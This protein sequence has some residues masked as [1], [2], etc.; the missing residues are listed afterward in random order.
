M[1]RTT[2]PPELLVALDRDSVV[3]LRVQLEGELRR[4]IRSDRLTAETPLPSTRALAADLG[5]SR[6]VVVEAYDQLLA[7]GYLKAARGSATRVATRCSDCGDE[8]PEDATAL[9][10]RYDF[11]PGLPDLALFPRAEWLCA[12]RY[13]VMNTAESTFDYPDP[14]GAHSARV[15]LAAYL[16]RVRGTSARADRLLFCTGSSQG[17]ALIAQVLRE[18]GL[19]RIAVEDPGL[20]DQYEVLVALGLE[21]SRVPVDDD[22]LRVDRLARTR[23]HAVLVTPAHQYPTGAVLSP[24]RRAALLAWAEKRGGIVI[25]DDYDAEYRYD[26]QPV[27][28]LQGLAPDRVVY[29]G[30]ASKTLSP[31]LRLAWLISPAALAPDLARAKKFADFGSPVPEQLALEEFLER[32]DYDRHIRRTRNIYRRRRD[33]LVAA[34]GRHVPGLRIRG[35]A[36]GLHLMVELEEGADEP[37]IAASAAQR[38]IRVFG[39]RKYRGDPEAG[40]PALVLGYGGVD[41]SKIDE[42]IRRLAAVLHENG[43]ARR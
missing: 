3:P 30:T 27:G 36:A 42:G 13:A 40:P 37:A 4:A 29:L 43:G 1:K 26:R 35:M 14:R 33:A 6:G 39:A 38:S 20:N 24:E 22:G 34:L 2:S 19:R 5:V 23:A 28:S 17:V 21:V 15:G 16:N 32:G 41:E 8:A 12:L 25:E 10:P 18:R 31:A 7:E 9:R 11:R